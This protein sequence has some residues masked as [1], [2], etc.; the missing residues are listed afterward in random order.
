MKTLF[1]WNVYKLM[2]MYEWHPW[3][4]NSLITALDQPASTIIEILI[5]HDIP[6]HLFC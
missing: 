1:A 5:T 2:Q 3:E 4:K 6:G